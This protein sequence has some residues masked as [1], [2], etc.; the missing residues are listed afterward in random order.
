MENSR[1]EMCG[2]LIA[3]AKTAAASATECPPP[4][5]CA[6]HFL[7]RRAFRVMNVERK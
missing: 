7:P 3:N 4:Q 5:A 1:G 2:Q 6:L